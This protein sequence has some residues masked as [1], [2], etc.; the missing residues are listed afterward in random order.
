MLTAYTA[1]C[2]TKQR[3]CPSPT[4]TDRHNSQPAFTPPQR[5]ESGPDHCEATR[6]SVGAIPSTRAQ[7]RG[8]GV[9][10]LLAAAGPAHLR[11]HLPVPTHPPALRRRGGYRVHRT[12]PLP[13]AR[14]RWRNMSEQ[15]AT[16]E[17]T[18]NQ[19][20]LLA[21]PKPPLLFGSCPRCGGAAY[22]R[23]WDTA[24]FCPLHGLFYEASEME[25]L[26]PSWPIC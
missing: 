12:H 18:I 19:P 7:R 24:R 11:G 21:S 17:R 22:R 4:N 3:A 9:Q 2:S 6:T 23:A 25:F 20:L 5:R 8:S 1:G 13:E 26:S 16:G 14:T 15:P 10:E